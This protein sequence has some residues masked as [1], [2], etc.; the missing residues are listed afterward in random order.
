M[1]SITAYNINGEEVDGSKEISIAEHRD[2]SGIE[3]CF[4]ATYNHEPFNP[5]GSYSRKIKDTVLKSVD[6]DLFNYYILFLQTRN[7]DYLHRV[8]RGLLDG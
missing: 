7:L 1:L 3:K 5:A 2:V 6:K 8:R 4:I